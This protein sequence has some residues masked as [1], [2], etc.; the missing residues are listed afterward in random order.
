MR[1]VASCRLACR[2]GL[3]NAHTYL[4]HTAQEH[5]HLNQFIVHA[6]LDV[7]DDV[8]WSSSSAYLK[9]VDRFNEWLVSA[10]VMPS[11]RRITRWRSIVAHVDVH[12]TTSFQ[13]SGSCC[14][15]TSRTRMASGNSLPNVMSSI[16]RWAPG[17]DL[18]LRRCMTFPTNPSTNKQKILMNPFYTPG[19]P[20]SH[21]AFDMKVKAAARRYLH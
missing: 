10:Y 21:A 18:F 11:S 19:T 3:S 7:V 5:R 15:T 17:T 16:S 6:A 2:H 4:P 14:C 12:Q 1:R 8:Q 20:I 9:V 13:T